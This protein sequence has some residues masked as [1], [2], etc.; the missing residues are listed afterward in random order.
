MA[1]EPTPGNTTP[2]AALP[3]PAQFL[4]PSAPSVDKTSPMVETG[5]N[6]TKLATFPTASKPE[7]N[8]VVGVTLD[9]SSRSATAEAAF[10]M[11]LHRHNGFIR[12]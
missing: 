2:S 6:G 12:L 9:V 4:C 10:V 1:P 7:K 8:P 11:R 5:S 3:A